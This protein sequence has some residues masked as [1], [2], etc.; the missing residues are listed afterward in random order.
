MSPEIVVP[1]RD[2]EDLA[3]DVGV[4]F[5]PPEDNVIYVLEEERTVSVERP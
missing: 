4:V 1:A 5:I 2:P 3:F